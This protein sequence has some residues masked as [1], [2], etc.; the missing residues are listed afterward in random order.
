M[1][2]CEEW[3]DH[4]LQRTNNSGQAESDCKELLA[5]KWAADPKVQGYT[6]YPKVSVEIKVTIAMWQRKSGRHRQG[7]KCYT[8]PGEPLERDFL[9]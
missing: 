4:K 7:Q 9:L 2:L 8:H 1:W 3:F 5:E 6:I